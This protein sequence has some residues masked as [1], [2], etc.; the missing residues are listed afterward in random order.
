MLSRRGSNRQ[1]A[2]AATPFTGSLQKIQKQCK[3]NATTPR[4]S[5][6]EKR[7][8]RRFP[9]PPS[10]LPRR[11]PLPGGA[12]PFFGPSVS[13]ELCCGQRCTTGRG[14]CLGS[15]AQYAPSTPAPPRPARSPRPVA[16]RHP[17]DE[18]ARDGGTRTPERAGSNDARPVAVPAWARGLNTLRGR[19]R[20]LARRAR[21][22]T[23]YTPQ[24]G[25]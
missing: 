13:G 21:R 5:L 3:R 16:P 14:A 12:A 15:G 24:V 18:L 2:A 9:S 4:I 22:E 8:T 19:L 25:E 23:G 20:P 11:S 17:R 7:S 10:S 1:L 6:R